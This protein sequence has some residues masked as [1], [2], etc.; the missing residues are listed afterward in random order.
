MNQW[1]Y[2]RL[3]IPLTIWDVQKEAEDEE[4][5]IFILDRQERLFKQA[6][7]SKRYD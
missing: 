5:R 4:L 2:H 6:I 3:D 7:G 1:D